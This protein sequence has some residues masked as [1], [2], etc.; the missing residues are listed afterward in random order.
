MTRARFAT[1]EEIGWLNTKPAA[2]ER[3]CGHEFC[4]EGHEGVTR[5]RDA[6][7]QDCPDDATRMLCVSDHYGGGSHY[8]VHWCPA[9]GKRYTFDSYA[10]TLRAW[11]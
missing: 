11:P 5:E 3:L 10:F 7:P 4:M 2:T 6:Y 1:A 9:C 8:W